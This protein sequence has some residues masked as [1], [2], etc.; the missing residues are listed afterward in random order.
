MII[1]FKLLPVPVQDFLGRFLDL[2]TPM[3]A[4]GISEDNWP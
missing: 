4:G 3:L 2:L 1:K